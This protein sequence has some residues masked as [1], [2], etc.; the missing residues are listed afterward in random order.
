MASVKRDQILQEADKLAA[1]GKF[2]AAIREYKRAL[3]QLPNDTNTLNRL[4][5]LLVRVNRIAEAIDVYQ[6]IADHFGSDGFFLKAIAIYKKVNRLDPQR[7]EV[8]E[9]LAD[10]YFKQG[11]VVEGRQQLLTLAD[12]FL[13]SRDVTE[14]IRVYRRLGELEPANVQA[15]AKLVDLLVQKGD[16]AGVVVEIDALGHNLLNRGMLDE[17]VKLYHRALELKPAETEFVAPCLDALV[18][19][20]RIPQAVE[21][22]NRAL[23]LTKSGTEIRRAAARAYSEAG[24]LAR[25]R[26]VLE[27]LLPSVGERTDVIQLY[28]DVLL[29]AGDAE[30]AKESVLP[31]ADRLAHAG[32]TARAAALLRRLLRATPGDVDVL[33]RAAKVFDRREDP[34]MV[35][36][37]ET[38]LAEAYLR[39]ERRHDAL[40][41]YR[42]LSQTHPE[43]PVFGQRFA[44]LGGRPA[45]QAAPPPESVPL[46]PSPPPP[47]IEVS[48]TQAPE[49]EVEFVDVEMFSEPGAAPDTP[50]VELPQPLGP[51]A[52]YRAASPPAPQSAEPATVPAGAPA[53]T[54][55]ELF[56]EAVVFAK[57]GLTDKAVSHLQRLLVLDPGHAQGLELLQSLGGSAPEEVAAA[58]APAPVQEAAQPAP[59]TVDEFAAFS[60][61]MPQEPVPAS[62]S[63]VG[64]VRLEDLEAILGLGEQAEPLSEPAPVAAETG[65]HIHFSLPDAA[66]VGTPDATSPLEWGSAGHA[67]E[68]VPVAPVPAAMTA[69]AAPRTGEASAEASAEVPPPREEALEEAV[70]LLEVPE[71]MAGP[72][73]DRLREVDFLIAQGLLDEAAAELAKAREGFENHPEVTARQALLKARGWDEAAP[74]AVA[75]SSAAELFSEEEQFFDL[76]AE[77]EKELAE[78]E[79][80][81]EARGAEPTGEVSIEE[82]F[83]EFQRGVAEQVHEEDYDTHF[84]LGLAYRE[85]GLLDEAIGE[86]QMATKSPALFVEGA[87]MIG[88]CYVDKGLPEQ[89]ADWYTRALGAPDLAPEA[90]IGLKYELGRAHE[91][92]GNT[93]AALACFAEVLALNPGFRDVVDRVAKLQLQTN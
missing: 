91:L 44:E 68:G 50:G 52:A 45:V 92:N 1:R 38:A 76:A 84:N 31:A 32:D 3:E 83:R 43:N 72:S 80:V 78:D 57:Y 35:L 73:E 16:V 2:D 75:E 37:V 63:G 40:E 34:D 36:S 23:G 74:A 6:R 46:V 62:R 61:E 15:R 14:A 53:T 93:T 26:R 81:A 20:G 8:Y 42:A 21:M 17:A 85:M 7:T 56:T 60:V 18:K 77:L 10:L 9:K 5:D 70:E 12:W 4:G 69:R 87:S 24:D 79:M 59:S 65:G 30:T 47:V 66:T 13:R 48:Q 67:I 28:G 29:R 27:E 19:G 33:E 39:A 86:F 71:V 41:L 90:G 51:A 58:P 49:P 54:A 11:L 25:A 88:A 55:E 89:A 64:R 22:A 82:L